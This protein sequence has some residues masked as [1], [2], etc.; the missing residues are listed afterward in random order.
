MTIYIQQHNLF[1]LAR[2]KGRLKFGTSVFHSYV[3]SWSCQLDYNPRINEG[4]GLSDGEGCERCWCK[5]CKLVAAL[6]Y[7]TKQHRIDAVDLKA[8]HENIVLRTN[9][10]HSCLN[11]LASAEK[12]RAEKLLIL[13]ELG[14]KH[15]HT[16][17]Y[18]AAQWERQKRIQ[19]EVIG[20]TNVQQ[21]E[22]QIQELTE[23]EEELR[24]AKEKMNYLRRRRRRSPAENR[25]LEGLPGHITFLEEEVERVLM[26]LG[27]DMFKN[28]P[29]ASDE[30]GRLLIQVKVAKSNLYEAKV[31]I[32]E[33]SKKWASGLC[34]SMQDRM[35]GIMTTKQKL[36]KKKWKMFHDLVEQYNGSYPNNNPLINY[37]LK[38]SKAL[39]LDDAFW[40]FGHLSHPDEDWATDADTQKGIQ[41][42]LLYC[43][44]E[45]ELRKISREVRQM[46]RWSLAMDA[47][48]QKALTLSKSSRS[49]CYL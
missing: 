20:D 8:A 31:G 23:H 18:F 27:G 46:L 2:S 49:R 26:E 10:V 17:A 44:S 32:I 12:T 7:A 4:W 6:R 34:T 30:C 13:D 29:D 5:L 22:A 14:K 19:A 36:F 42:Y 45:E 21:L 37:T 38:E 9:S 35:K 1:E 33:W 16:H 3:H 39:P 48:I 40:N 28:I 15:G 43:R 41:A 47:K 25:T 24:E 11:K